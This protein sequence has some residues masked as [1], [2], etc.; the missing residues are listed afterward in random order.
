M[1]PETRE[2]LAQLR[3]LLERISA[4]L[5]VLEGS[6]RPPE[7][8]QTP[9]EP[10][11]KPARPPRA[12]EF[13]EVSASPSRP[14]LE[15]RIGSQWLNR[16]GIIA[17]L[18]GVAYFLKYAFE[19]NWIGASGRIVIGLIAGI[20]V[21]VWSERFRRHGSIAFS[22][23]LKA[24]GLGVLYLSLWASFQQYHLV[25]SGVAFGAM[26]IVTAS[27]LALALSQNAQVLAAMALMGGFLTPALVSTGEDHE[28]FLFA[29]LAILSATAVFLAVR[30]GWNLLVVTAFLGTFGYFVAWSS[31]FYSE[32]AFATTFFFVLLF[33]AIFL[34]PSVFIS[35]Q[36]G[37]QARGVFSV[38]LLANAVAVFFAIY[39][40]FDNPQHRA[41]L[42]WIVLAMAG[43][44][45]VGSR[46]VHVETMRLLHIA[47][48]LGL[49]TVA[50][51]L[52]FEAH[53]I[54]LGW[55]VES[56][57]ILYI[58][59]RK[60]NKLLGIGGLVA[61][62]FA[63]ARLVFIDNFHPALA[64]W[65]MRVLLF[66]I[67]IA[68]TAAIA[69]YGRKHQQQELWMTSAIAVTVLTLFGLDRELSFLL[70]P[71]VNT[72]GYGRNVAEEWRSAE[73]ALNFARSAIWMAYGVAAMAFGFIKRV[74]FYRYL[75]LALLSIT[76]GKVFLYD[77][78]QLNQGYRV[79]SF[80]ALGIILL[81]VSYAYQRD[82]LKLA[83]KGEDRA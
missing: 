9:G 18:F 64:F 45:I 72:T 31:S 55:L 74:P 7:L 17:V 43:V 34:V 48:A 70:L 59:A 3:Q 25:P 66:A 77:I 32:Q 23:S 27:A 60:A 29:Y 47:I 65:N 2:E 81:A 83:A 82:W 36:Q 24:V 42:P 62:A 20:A 57:A 30:R 39:W 28:I 37:A 67:A 53:F 12:P 38:L 61:L 10:E 21:V 6:L 63:V 75:S 49:I 26:V 50:I 11:V 73:I 44:Y 33:Y 15:A 54:T 58:A 13:K 51:P 14:G 16:I 8:Q 19:S 76:I 80:I 79:I 41:S 40:L 52:K 35:P 4:R 1:T 71:L 68:I 69:H 5:D 22:H 78:E 46:R 56:A